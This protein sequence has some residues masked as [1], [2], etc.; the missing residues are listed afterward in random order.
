MGAPELSSYIMPGGGGDPREGLAQARLAESIGLGAIWLGERIDTKDFPSIIGALS[1]VTSSIT[2]GVGVTPMNLRHPMVLAAAG[3]T[4]QALC[5]GRFRLGF[6]KSAD[7]RWNG[8]GYPAPTIASMRDVAVILRRLWA[9]ETVSYD[10]PAGRFPNIRLP[11]LLDVPPPPLYLAAVG[12]KTIEM[13]GAEF[14]GLILHPFLTLDAVE[15][16]VHTAR[17]AAER[18]GRDPRSLKIVATV[19]AAPGMSEAESQLAAHARAAGYFSVNGLGDALVAMNGWSKEAHRAYRNQPVLVAL[20]DKP[21]DKA[22][23]RAELIK[24]TEG[25]P[26]DWIPSSCA[27]GTVEQVK[28]RLRAYLAAGADEILIHGATAENLGPLVGQWQ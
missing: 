10:G 26:A 24:L 25:M 27:L 16:A 28:A 6:G 1:Q 23:S 4:L 17:Q 20:G 11:A 5:D 18:A 8:Y 13:A 14:D 2:L 3:Q 9:G 22:L 19:V 12:P 21:A 15:R 7:W